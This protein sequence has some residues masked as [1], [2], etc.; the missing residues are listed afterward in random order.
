MH[1]IDWALLTI[2]LAS[3]TAIGIYFSRRQSSVETFLQGDSRIGWMAVGLSLMAALNSGM[4]YIQ[5]PAVVFVFG[6]VYVA[7]ILTWIPL[8]PWVAWVT[9]PFYRRLNV[10]SA[11]E[12]LERRFGLG[13]RLVA[14]AI[15]VLWRISW[16]GVALYVPC[17]AL[18]GAAGDDLDVTTLAIVLGIVVTGYTMLGGM[19]A[20]IWSDLLQFCVMFG[21]LFATVAIIVNQVPGGLAAVWSHA[22]DSGR[23]S[24]EAPLPELA[25]TDL[26]ARIARYLTTEVTLWGTL[27]FI[28][29]GRMATYTSDQVAVQRFQ[30]MGSYREARNAFI[31]SA[32]AD[33]LW[34]VVLGGV[35]LSLFA[36]FQSHPFPAGLK[37]DLILP[38][39]MSQHF[40]AGFI[41]LVV[42]S[43]LSASLSSVDAALNATTSVIVVDFYNRWWLGRHEAVS[44]GP[45]S[46]QQRMVWVTRVINVALGVVITLIAAS[47]EHLGEIYTVGNKLFGA[48]FG[49]LFGV[50]ALGMFSRSATGRGALCGALAGLGTSCFF[51][52]FSALTPLHEP[53]RAACGDACVEFCARISWQWPPVLGIAVTLIVGEL[54]S[55]CLPVRTEEPPLT[56]W[57]VMQLPDPAEQRA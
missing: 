11:Y 27:C 2:Y 51:S 10:V 46:E 42:A 28:V 40:T 14:S 13:V 43:I 19:Q 21:G 6:T 48:F 31:V 25:T 1:T 26:G 5:T 57:R 8:Y 7:L 35:G 22:V 15:F 56:Y 39:F 34:M 45:K 38:Y 4:D 17:L 32:L 49:I 54:A 36:Y 16:M 41:G 20:V 23:L 3:L 37:N 9:V 47:V 53:I 30:T 12:Y 29:I 44:S 18:K 50:F 24:L 52:F 55:R 33:I